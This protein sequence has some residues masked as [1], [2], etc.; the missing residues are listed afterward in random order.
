MSKAIVWQWQQYSGVWLDYDE[1]ASAALEFAFVDGLPNTS[2][3]VSPHVGR[4]VGDVVVQ[5]DFK[6]MTQTVDI[7]RPIR[8]IA[9]LD[10]FIP[11]RARNTKL[12][13]RWQLDQNL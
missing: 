10:A 3:R 7:E 6:K 2:I 4:D 13:Q 12:I 9:I 11:T 5:V 8:R 1:H